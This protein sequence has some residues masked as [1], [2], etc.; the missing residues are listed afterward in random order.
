[1]NEHILESDWKVLR[2][3]KPVLLDRLCGRILDACRAAMDDPGVT[4]HQCYLALFDLLRRRDGELATAFDDLRRS[5]AIIRLANMYALDLFTP[6]ELDRFSPETR[7]RF[8]G[9]AEPRREHFGGQPRR[10]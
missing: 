8:V 2:D 9:L 1:M 5:T 4:A 7:D 3:L 10:S 6:D